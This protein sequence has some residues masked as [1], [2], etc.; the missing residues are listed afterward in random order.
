MKETFQVGIIGFGDMGRLYAEYIS[1]AGWR[2][3][4]CDR[5]ENYESIQATYGNGGYTVLKDGFQVSRTSDYILYSVEAEHIDKVVALYGPATKVG[6]IVGGQTSCKAPEMNAFEKYLPED[7]DIISCHSMHGPKVNP[8]S[9]PLV[10]IRHRA[11]DEHF[12]I[13]N[14]ILSCFKSSVVYLSAKEHD[15]ITA[16]TQA[17]THAA[18][19]TMGL[20]WHANNQYPWEINRWCGGIENI[21]MNLSMRIYSS[22]WHVYAGLAILNPE[23]QRQIQQYASSVTE[24]FKLAISGKAKEYEDRIRNAGKFVF[25]ENM[26]R[27]SSGLLLSDE[28]LDQYSISNI[29]KDESKRNSHL[30]ILAIVDSWSKLGIHPQNHMICSTPLFRL[31]VGVSEYVFRHPGLLDSCIYTATKHNDFSPD[32][33]EFVV[34]VR[35]WSECVAA[36]DFTTYKKRFLETQEYFRPRFEEATRVGNAMISKLLENLQKM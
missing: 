18:F 30:S 26:D 27:N 5:P 34:A 23:A 19:L 7:V 15:R 3:N 10:I 21:K 11:S 9:Q 6:A 20:A 35:S 4:V 36:K 1:K 16:D 14:E 31:W 33:L 24:L 29:P 28:L 17:V 32:D 13:V 8:K 2:V 12:E 25:G 22:K